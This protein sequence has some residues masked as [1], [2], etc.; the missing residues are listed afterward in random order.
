MRYGYLI[1]VTC[2][3]IGLMAVLYVVSN[4]RASF[5]ADLS[6]E[7]DGAGTESGRADQ[8]VVRRL[9]EGRDP[10]FWSADISPDGRF[11][12]EVAEGGGGADVPRSP[13]AQVRAAR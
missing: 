6:V 8:L 5:D 12:T 13:G 1:T 7:L 2:L 4:S 11:M 3:S 9:W 10:Q